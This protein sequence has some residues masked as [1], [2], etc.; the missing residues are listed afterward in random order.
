M[1]KLVDFRVPEE[2]GYPSSFINFVKNDAYE[3]LQLHDLMAP[4]GLTKFAK[5]GVTHVIIVRYH[6]CNLPAND[7]VRETRT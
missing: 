3:K 6:T 1:K 4:E 7:V 5:N 2:K